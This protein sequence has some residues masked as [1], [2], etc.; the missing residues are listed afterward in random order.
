MKFFD[1]AITFSE[2][3]FSPDGSLTFFTGGQCRYNCEGC[4]WGKTKPEGIEMDLDTFDGILKKKRKHTKHLCILGEGQDQHDLVNYLKVA[5]YYDYKVM[6]Y[7]G[8]ELQDIIPEVLYM[9]DY[10]KTG[11]WEG[12]TLYEKDTNQCVYELMEGHV[13]RTFNFNKYNKLTA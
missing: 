12:K 4:S 1:Y 2:M 7:T 9:L 13:I 3:P 6:L 11:R 10:L 5:K 8:G